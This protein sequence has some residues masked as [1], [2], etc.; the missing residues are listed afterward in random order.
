MQVN[1][2][3]SLPI[4]KTVILLTLNKYDVAKNKDNKV[5]LNK[6]VGQMI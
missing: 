6:L 2:K 3:E 1:T 5:L 4:V